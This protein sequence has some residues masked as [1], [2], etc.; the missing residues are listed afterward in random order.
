MIGEADIEDVVKEELR[1]DD[2]EI[3]VTS[4]QIKTLGLKISAMD[5][6]DSGL[7]DRHTP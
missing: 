3:D 1:P 5:G 2:S 6:E 4:L 7:G